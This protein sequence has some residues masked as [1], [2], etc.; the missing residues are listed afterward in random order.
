MPLCYRLAVFDDVGNLRIG[1]S[2]GSRLGK[3]D[4]D[5]EIASVVQFCGRQSQRSDQLPGR[6][7]YLSH[8][9]GLPFAGVR[10]LR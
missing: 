10:G 1:A 3:P 2:A 9:H 8:K 5:V 4:L 6:P 7:G